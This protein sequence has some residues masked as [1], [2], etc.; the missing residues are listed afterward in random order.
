VVTNEIDLGRGELQPTFQTEKL[1]RAD[2]L[3]IK[4]LSQFLRYPTIVALGTLIEQWC[5]SAYP[6]LCVESPERHIYPLQLGETV[7]QLR[8]R[9]ARGG[10]VFVS[11]YS[12]SFLDAIELDEVGRL[13]RGHPSTRG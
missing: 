10:Q 13:W 4:G 5:V 6:L 2:L 3:A 9:V 12:P 7:K 1:K 8:R 11:T